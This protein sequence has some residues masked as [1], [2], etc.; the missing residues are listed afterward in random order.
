MLSR[1][2]SRAALQCQPMLSR[3][4]VVSVQMASSAP[5]PAKPNPAIPKLEDLEDPIDKAPIVP[6]LNKEGPERDLV[7]FPRPVQ[8]EHP[9]PV[10]L[11]FIPE[12]YFEFFYKKTGVSGPYMFG[13]GIWTWLLSK[14]IYV[15]E[16]NFYNGLSML[17]IISIIHNKMGPQIAA[18]ADKQIDQWSKDT[19]EAEDQEKVDIKGT[20][21]DINDYNSKLDVYKDIMNARREA[22]AAAQEALYREWQV[23]AYQEAKKRLD[24]QVDLATVERR[25]AQKNMSSWITNN[26][27][28]SITPAQE[29]EALKKCISDLKSLSASA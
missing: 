7:N 20:I 3:P 26:V 23:T 15:L 29:A 25:I 28:K 4:L 2:A 19:K 14:E 6:A 16:H 11:A 18:W 13:I 1:L 12:E 21:A 9:D 8:K 10:R 22:A 17:L 24:Y 27:L 5:A